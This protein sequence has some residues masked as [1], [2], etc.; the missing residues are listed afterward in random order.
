[1]HHIVLS[2]AYLHNM[3]VHARSKL[4]TQSKQ[5]LLQRDLKLNRLSSTC[6][7]HGGISCQHKITEISFLYAAVSSEY[8]VLH[9]L[10]IHDTF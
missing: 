7:F 1:M 10:K 6:E 2:S 9:A 5:Q 4:N 8:S 3:I